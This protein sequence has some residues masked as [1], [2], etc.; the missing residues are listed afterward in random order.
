MNQHT[1]FYRKIIY[2]VLM[3]VLLFPI[4]RLGAPATRE[5]QGGELA[6]LRKKHELGQSDLGE[7]DPASETIRLATL[8]M[9]GIAVSLLWN[10]ANE[11]KKKEDWTN[12]RAT[13]S[14]LAR[15]QPYFISFW[16]YQAWNL[17]YNVSVELDDVRDRF[18]YVKRGIEF[19]KEG[20][21]YN[22]NSHYLLSDLGWF[23]GNKIGR[24]DE[25]VEYRRLF[26]N[27]DDFHPED[28]PP[29]LRDNWLV[30]KE[31]YLKAVS[32]IDDKKRSLGNRNPTTFFDKPAMA[33]IN[34]STAIEE[35]GTFGE[36]ARAAWAVASRL[37]TEYGNREMLSSRGTILQLASYDRWLKDTEEQKARLEEIAPTAR[38]EL[39]KARREALSEDL[40][41]ALEMTDEE[42]ATDAD[43]RRLHD[44]ALSR[45]E[46]NPPDIIAY[47]AKH[48]S[49]DLREARKLVNRIVESE[50]HLSL[51]RNNRQ[52]ANYEFWDVRCKFEQTSEAIKAHELAY[53]ARR[54]FK[55]GDLI[56]ARRLYEESLGLW[57]KVLELYPDMVESSITGS[58]IMEFIKSYVKVLEQLE[59]TLSD[60][61]VD[62][63]FPL[64]NIIQGHDGERLFLKDYELHKQREQEE[65]INQVD[66]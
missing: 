16:R 48:S 5:D 53:S 2:L 12:F 3:A 21:K 58:D 45:L 11:Y 46:V 43:K 41:A 25:H 37:W 62:E 65:K 55:D 61:E 47:I 34:Y 19:L 38:E 63:K 64:W 27:D 52:T 57:A 22:R 15:L 51:I 13:L 20:I 40:R 59:L 44:E 36:Q 30:S 35:E 60:K 39:A 8:G 17:S 33:Q 56:E 32:T 28:R 50:L 1:T 23:I 24:A 4:S 29:E 31:W 26:K 6:Q 54:A 42:I 10:K 49:E 14:Q 66:Q 18:Y 9:R 7:I